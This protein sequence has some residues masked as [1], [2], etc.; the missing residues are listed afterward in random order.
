MKP[1]CVSVILPVFD[2]EATLGQALDSVRG[3]SLTDWELIA[4]DD[5]S[6]DGSAEILESAA[7][8]DPRIQVHTVP[9]GGLPA[10]LNLALARSRAPLLARMDADDT[11][12]PDRLR[13][14]VDHLGTHPE[15]GLVASR[16]RFGGDRNQAVGYAHYIDWTNSIVSADE[17]GLNRFVESPLVHPSVTFRRE[18]AERHGGY[19]GVD[20]PED[21]ELWLR[22]LEAGVRMEKRPEELLVWNDPPDRLSRNHPRYRVEAFYA[23]KCR[24]LA[25]WIAQ[26][27]PPDRPKVL[28]G[29][30][31]ITRKRFEGLISAGT[32]LA[33]YIDISPRRI[34]TTINGLPVHAPTDLPPETRWFVISAVG[35]RDARGPIRDDLAGRGYVEGRDF[36]MAA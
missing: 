21:Y 15:V 30:G 35:N 1:P 17:I 18:V 27:V 11:C 19:L 28:W 31:R 29:A 9:H 32:D 12:H 14:Q 36:I 23:C 13:I 16:V 24:F 22:W 33:G 4:I 6:T 3:Q 2:A 26:Q 25:R 34:G 8:E 20:A 7:A 5:G 10:A